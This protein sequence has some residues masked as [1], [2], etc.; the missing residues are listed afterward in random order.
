LVAVFEED[1]A[2]L[3]LAALAADYAPAMAAMMPPLQ[4][5]EVLAASRAGFR[6]LVGLPFWP[7]IA[8]R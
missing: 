7:P 6:A 2:V 4:H 3:L 8:L 1:D 5:V